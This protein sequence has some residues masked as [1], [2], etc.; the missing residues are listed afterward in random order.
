MLNFFDV[1]KNSVILKLTLIFTCFIL[2]VEIFFVC[3]T[4]QNIRELVVEETNTTASHSLQKAGAILDQLLVSLRLSAQSFSMDD[5]FLEAVT[6]QTADAALRNKHVQTINSRLLSLLAKFPDYRIYAT[7]VSQDGTFY[8][9]YSAETWEYRNR[10][11]F[12]DKVALCRNNGES[13]IYRDDNYLSQIDRSQTEPLLTFVSL[14]IDPDNLKSAG[15]VILSIPHTEIKNLLANLTAQPDSL[16]LLSQSGSLVLSL[17]MDEGEYRT[18][19]A[20]ILNSLPEGSRFPISQQEYLIHHTSLSSGMVLTEL[21][22]CGPMLKRLSRLE[23]QT[24]LLVFLSFLFLLCISILISIFATRTLRQLSKNMEAATGGNLAIQME[25]RSRDEIGRLVSNF[26]IL[27]RRIRELLEEQKTKDEQLRRLEFE[28]LQQQIRPHFILN[29]LNSIRWMAV[30][31]QADNIRDMISA[32]SR[33]LKTSIYTSDRYL[34]LETELLNL[35]DYLKLQRM[36][37]NG[38]F[39]VSIHVDETLYSCEVLKMI[40]QPI[41]ENALIH[42]LDLSCFDS[43]IKID[44]F[45]DGEDLVLLVYDNGRGMDPQVQ[46][47]LNR[48]LSGMPS[49]QKGVGILNVHQR[50]RLT[51]GYPYGIQLMS[52]PEKGTAVELRLPYRICKNTGGDAHA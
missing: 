44:G 37:F 48:M 45:L 3:S 46:E 39:Q 13:W 24:F 4:F 30:L 16:F 21:I 18:T 41:V 34:S 6:D 20:A 42:G 33:L 14:I 15:T 40:L 50:L 12:E 35:T 36:R 49:M 5:A 22:P 47:Q 23:A 25:V 38:L 17:H 51:Y 52:Q 9:S 10:L 1:L 31:S 11:S 7:V 43:L 28:A 32:L 27:I 29:T 8:C 26:N 2:I 19:D